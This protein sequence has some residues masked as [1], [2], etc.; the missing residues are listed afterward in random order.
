MH[1][2]LTRFKALPAIPYGSSSARDVSGGVSLDASAGDDERPSW[3]FP[4]D[5]S[6]TVGLVIVAELLRSEDNRCPHLSTKEDHMK[7]FN[8]RCANV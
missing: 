4:L 1:L 7:Y 8:A 5:S 3:L 2:H 6:S